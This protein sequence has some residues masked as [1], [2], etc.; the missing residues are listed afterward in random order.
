[1]KPISILLLTA[2]C[3]VALSAQAQ[4]QWTEKS[5]RKVFSDQPP[6]A[7]IPE[8]A[9]LRRPGGP[10]PNPP[11][12]NLS[13]SESGEAPVSKPIA[14]KPVTKASGKDMELEK[15]KAL[16]ESQAA[17]KK[18]E[19]D[20]KLAANRADNCERAKRNL[21]SLQSGARISQTNAQGERE[22]M[23]DEGKAAEIQRTQG[24]VDANCR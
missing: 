2:L 22:F 16:A 13:P 21:A 23:T 15:K 19:D 20:D 4:W 8:S 6:G 24:I 1:M 7:E 11:S 17:A 18:K 10:R 3:G 14:V 5:G 9:I 12:S